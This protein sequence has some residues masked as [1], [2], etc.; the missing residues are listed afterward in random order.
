M[1]STHKIAVKA[2][3]IKREFR[4]VKHQRGMLLVEVFF[5]IQLSTAFFTITV[6]SGQLFCEPNA[7]CFLPYF[8][9]IVAVK[10][11]LSACIYLETI[12][13]LTSYNLENR[14][15]LSYKLLICIAVYFVKQ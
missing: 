6:A 1:L 15:I 14:L 8:H 5:N 7:Y 11:S 4:V 3:S 2:L 13:K 12:S 10:Y 9:L